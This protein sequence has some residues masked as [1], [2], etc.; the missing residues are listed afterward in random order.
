MNAHTDM[1]VC[2]YVFSG[3]VLEDPLLFCTLPQLVRR[4]VIYNIVHERFFLMWSEDGDETQ[5][6]VSL[7]RVPVSRH[8]VL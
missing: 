5:Q 1:C 6:D 2:V 8:A 7:S 4:D 3:A